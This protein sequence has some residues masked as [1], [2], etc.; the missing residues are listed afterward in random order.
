VPYNDIWAW[1]VVTFLIVLLYR[2]L[3]L[4]VPLKPMGRTT[5]FVGLLPVLVY[6]LSGLLDVLGGAPPA[7]RMIVPFAMGIPVC[8][9]L[10]GLLDRVA[11]WRALAEVLG[12]R[13]AGAGR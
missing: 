3:E 8:L 7:V 2:I 11:A 13:R 5:A 12:E 4:R 9:A 6:A 10:D 1:V